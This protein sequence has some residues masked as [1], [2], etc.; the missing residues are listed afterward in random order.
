MEIELLKTLDCNQG[1]VRAVRFNVD[2]EY[3]LTCGSDKKLKLWNPYRNLLLKTYAGHGNEVL[4]AC[5][6]CDSS[7]IVSCGAD[8]SV[9]IWDVSSGTPLR[10]LRGHASNVTCVRFNEESSVAISGSLDNCV[11]CW[12][13]RSRK[14]EP[15][16]VL[17][18]AKDS[19]SSIQ[20]TNHMILTGSV[21][22]RI[23]QYDMRTGDLITDF[24]G[25]PVISASFTGDGQCVVVGCGD[26]CVRLFDKDSGE[27]LGEYSGHHTGEFRVESAV[28]NTDTF[29]L[30]GATDGNI[31]CW[32]MVKGEVATKLTHAPGVVVNS[33][34][35]HPSK[36]ALV[37]AAGQ[38][39]K[40]WGKPEFLDCD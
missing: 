25:E 13:V 20:I 29:I 38:T 40:L 10:R 36:S 5:G 15:I 28:D 21:D 4:D 9:I 3:C 2:G 23:R 22:C 31:W 16:Q 6:S 8:K 18:E 35:P 24:V 19:I 1:A 12:D 7:Q 34:H 11:M 33:I 17:K 14:N 32:D 39:V 37:S 27:M 30:S 26:E